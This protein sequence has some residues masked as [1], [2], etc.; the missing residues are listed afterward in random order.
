M[1]NFLQSKKITAVVA[2][3]FILCVI[4]AVF[5]AGV[6]V[7]IHKASFADRIGGAYYKVFGPAGGLLGSFDKDDFPA[8]HGVVGTI[9]KIAP[10]FAFIQGPNN[11]ERT[12]RLGSSTTILKYRTSIGPN[13]L[14][15][16]DSIVV[17]G[18]PDASSSNINADFIRVIPAISGSSTPNNQ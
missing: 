18:S 13:D 15:N 12:I 8:S 5:E 2:I 6:A 11:V 14:S 7:G 17:I 16:G 4:L 10:P 1:R 3:I 9:I